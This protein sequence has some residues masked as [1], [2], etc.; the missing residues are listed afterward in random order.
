VCDGS[1]FS[2]DDDILNNSI[3]IMFYQK[4]KSEDVDLDLKVV[5]N[6]EDLKTEN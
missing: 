5:G 3:K 6:I 1:I 4:E 2:V